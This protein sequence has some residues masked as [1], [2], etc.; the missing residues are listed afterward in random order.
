MNSEPFI[1]ID[2]EKV[3]VSELS[4]RQKYLVNQ[5]NDIQTK[6]AQLQFNADQ[7]NVALN[8]FSDEMKESRK[9]KE[10]ESVVA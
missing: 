8:V 5:I 9:K 2:S 6:L 4:E 3:F 1:Y 10:P 7:L